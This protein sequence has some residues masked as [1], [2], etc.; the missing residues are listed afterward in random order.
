MEGHLKKKKV[1][2]DC[3]LYLYSKLY[4]IP[5]FVVQIFYVII[6]GLLYDL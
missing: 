3:M 1:V 4:S 5:K 2:I 6:S